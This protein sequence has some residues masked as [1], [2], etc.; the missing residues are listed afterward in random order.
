M[1]VY[2]KQTLQ[3]LCSTIKMSNVK[4]INN[5]QVAIFAF[6]L[7]LIV[8]MKV[9][10]GLINTYITVLYHLDVLKTQISERFIK[11]YYNFQMSRI[12]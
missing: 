7:E 8:I 10:A 2:L 9:H 6:F 3:I 4:N 5:N 11:N 12:Q 1:V